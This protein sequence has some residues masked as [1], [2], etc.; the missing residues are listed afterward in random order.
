MTTYPTRYSRHP[1]TQIHLCRECL[2]FYT[3]R[4]ARDLGVRTY[5]YTR[6][7]LPR[8]L[9]R[10]SWILVSFC[11]P[12]SSVVVLVSLSLVP[13]VTSPESS[14]DSTVD[15]TSMGF[16]A[17]FAVTTTL[18]TKSPSLGVPRPAGAPSTPDYVVETTSTKMTA[19]PT[20][21]FAAKDLPLS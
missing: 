6:W 10:R 9:G 2:V 18:L 16:I 15:F 21:G 8:Q 12:L 3:T 20:T 13:A 11:L 5:T 4:R 17:T 1:T 7:A 14:R 19:P